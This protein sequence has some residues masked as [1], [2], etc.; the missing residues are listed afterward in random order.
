METRLTNLAQ[1]RKFTLE[2]ALISTRWLVIVISL[3]AA[4][5]ATLPALASTTTNLVIAAWA[6][7]NVY[8]TLATRSKRLPGE[9][10]VILLMG[11]DLLAAS[12]LLVTQQIN[13]PIAVA[14]YTVMVTAAL[15][16][17][18]MRAALSCFALVFLIYAADTFAQ[19]RSF[20][21]LTHLPIAP[22]SFLLAA[23]VVTAFLAS[24]LSGKKVLHQDQ[25]TLD[26]LREL[27]R[28]KSEFM[29]VA[30]HELRTPMTKIK[31]W[32]TLMQ[33]TKDHEKAAEVIREGVEELETET[34][35]LGRLIE[36]L[37]QVSQLESG[38]LNLRRVEI[39]LGSLL[40]DVLNR[41]GDPGRDWFRLTVDDD[42]R[43]AWGDPDRLRIVLGS[44]I[45][46][47]IKF[48]PPTDPVA[49]AAHRNHHMINI[50]IQDR[51]N[52]IP[53]SETDRVFASFYQVES[54]LIRQRGGFGIGLYLARMLTEGMG[55]KIWI[56]NSKSRGNTFVVSLPDSSHGHGQPDRVVATR[57]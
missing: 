36:T 13:S 2:R 40:P 29:Q 44:L 57:Q 51:G 50:E 9:S 45:D 32:V 30:S 7:L 16:F 39:D 21:A 46:N 22:L 11:A 33:Q 35:H 23:T 28:L 26:E 24:N 15:R 52:R 48:S 27:D 18:N 42:A 37:L 56:D 54:P 3:L 53:T 1:E 5:L 20:D 25:L 17:G 38:E 55:G 31:A 6:L 47:A 34:D 4:N 41:H 49:I 8:C 19:Y 10:E 43:S 12:L 14:F